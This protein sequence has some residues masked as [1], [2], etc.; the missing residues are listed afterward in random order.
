MVSEK[1]QDMIAR[2]HQSLLADIQS[3]KGNSPE[4]ILFLSFTDM[5]TR[6][7]TFCTTASSFEDCWKAAI[8]NFERQVIENNIE[9]RSL[10]IDW[11]D[12]IE[13]L[14]KADLEAQLKN[15]KRNYFRFG[16]S[17]DPMFEQAFLET[18]LNGNAM[19]YGGPSIVH[20]II[21]EANFNRYGKRQRGFSDI[22]VAD[23]EQFHIFSAQG[24]FVNDEDEFIHKL[25]GAGPNAGRRTIETLAVTDIDGLI[26]RGSTFLA[27]QIREDGRFIYGWHPCFDKEIGAYN[28]LRHTSTLY[29]MLEAWEVTQDNALKTVI[30]KGLAYLTE[31]LIKTVN[32]NGSE[33][34]FLTE[35]NG[36]IK[37]GGNAVCLL[38][39]VKYSELTGNKQ[40][41]PLLEK[42]ALGILHMQ[43]EATGKFSHVLTY[44]SLRVKAPFR[45]IYYDGE[46]AFGLMRLYSLTHDERWL[47]AV[48]K[49]FGY[50]IEA[51]HWKAHDHWLSYAVNEL[52]R[53]R[54]E[55]K[56]Y[57]FGIRNFADYLDFVTNRITTFPTLLELMMAA[58]QMVVRIQADP[59]LSGLLNDVD[60]KQFYFALERR[61]HHLLNGHFWPEL[62]MFYAN[63]ARIS[64]SFFIRHHAFRVRIDDVEHYLSGFVAYRKYRLAQQKSEEHQRF[65]QAAPTLERPLIGLMRAKGRPGPRTLATAHVAAAQ[66]IALYFFTPSD[67]NIVENTIN[68][69][70]FEHGKWVNKRIGFPHIIDNDEGSRSA[71]DVW[72]TLERQSTM[73]TIMLGGKAIT[74]QKLRDANIFSDMI[75]PDL[76]VGD[77][78]TT[79]AF[80]DEHRDVVFKPVRG[81]Q[82]NAVSLVSLESGIYNIQ[83]GADKQ[84]VSVDDIKDFI[85][86]TFPAHR[87]IAQKY[88]HSRTPSGL[89]FDVRLHLQRGEGGAWKTTKIYARIGQGK[90][91]TSNIAGGGS[92]ADGRI[93]IDG[94]FGVRARAVWQT[95]TNI[96]HEF[97]EKF[98]ALYDKQIDAIGLDLG[99]DKHGKPW[100][101][102]INSYPGTKFFEFDEAL[103]RVGYLKY[104]AAQAVPDERPVLAEAP[105]LASLIE[106]FG[107]SPDQASQ[108]DQIVSSIAIDNAPPTRNSV[109]LFYAAGDVIGCSKAALQKNKDRLLAIF[110]QSDK[111]PVEGVSYYQTRSLREGLIRAATTRR[112]QFKGHVF[113]VAGSVGKTS[114]THLLAHA[115]RRSGKSVGVN[116]AGNVPEYVAAGMATMPLNRDC[117]VFE[118]AGATAPDKEPIGLT[119]TRI[120]HPHICILSALTPAHMDK[121]ISMERA[122][123][124]KAAAFR[125]LDPL[126]TAIV[127]RDIEHFELVK[128]E[129]PS[130]VRMLTFGRHAEAD[131][132]WSERDADHKINISIFGKPFTLPFDVSRDAF[133]MNGLSVIAALIADGVAPADAALAIGGWTPLA[134]RGAV[135]NVAWKEGQI[136]LIDDAY[137][138]NPAS[139]TVALRELGSLKTRGRRIAVLSEMAELG[140]K[141]TDY[142][143]ALARTVRD[144]NIDQIFLLDS[145]AYSGFWKEIR[146][147]QRAAKSPALDV[148]K[149]ELV[150]GLQPGD[151][152]LIK[153][154]NAT[155]LHQLSRWFRELSAITQ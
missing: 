137:N 105:S 61:A 85:A 120:V 101:F 74:L 121:M 149:S 128:H 3:L 63:P 78:D 87:Y 39:L 82:G 115:L 9:V 68:A 34:A 116:G 90:T 1:L 45:I 113:C 109:G 111:A 131:I 151:T 8:K 5:K 145:D 147:E 6:A 58:Q 11:V 31:Q 132:R 72:K 83:L 148:L 81:A 73:T 84:T 33:L 123:S 114:T 97:P 52:T 53:Y 21:N 139:M 117:L 100:L 130:T 38:A 46:A 60:L 20:A 4:F 75:I 15:I 29:A 27:S 50:F 110:G 133:V 30:E 47:N 66:G 141:S 94:Q 19:L 88:I 135:V 13:E 55:R 129:I 155:G 102:E 142:H 95:L 57:E 59:A 43:D 37:L 76:C 127:N 96:A 98:Q 42:I 48:E 16:I 23:V 24:V 86:R 14:S 32:H 112:D 119:S 104:L 89:P 79:L 41:L 107:G 12:H 71:A 152:L 54:P 134:G 17:L 26:A 77:P 28:T 153:G 69:L 64:G 125:G 124:V 44:P 10:R 67:V 65:L 91:I 36:E 143:T 122:A 80:I 99:L 93:F 144:N 136:Q 70:K 7:T 92:I 150:A 40:Y 35:E 146:S 126:G 18:E 56:Y 106:A 49:A 62:A 51:D 25:P 118:V 154:S 108:S 138:A 140:N 2:V 103:I 22:S